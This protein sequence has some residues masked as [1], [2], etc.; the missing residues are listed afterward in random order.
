[1][2]RAARRALREE[3]PRRVA[4]VEA[5]P[6]SALA[7]GDDNALTW[8]GVPIARLK[9]G[10]SALRPRVQMLDSEFL[11]G[12][13]RERLRGRL[14]RFLDDRIGHDLAPLLAA[15]NK[16]SAQPGFRGLLHR[17]TEVARPDPW[18]RRRCVAPARP[19]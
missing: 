12:A 3:M 11:D 15:A 17:L 5:A 16:G 9:R 1:M 8:D 6:D 2:L 18:R 10:I 13:Q 7:F 14:Q 19:H 4:V